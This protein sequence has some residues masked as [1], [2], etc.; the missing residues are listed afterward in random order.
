MIAA[1]GILN[2]TTAGSKLRLHCWHWNLH[3][4]F[5]TWS[6]VYL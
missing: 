3:L 5:S 6:V 2:V 1:C 4:H